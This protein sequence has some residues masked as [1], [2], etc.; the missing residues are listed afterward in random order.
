MFSEFPLASPD[1]LFHSGLSPCHAQSSE[2]SSVLNSAFSEI[3][4]D[5]KRWA[6]FCLFTDFLPL[7]YKGNG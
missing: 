1:P 3:S 7:F 6:F 5:M 4:Q 2:P